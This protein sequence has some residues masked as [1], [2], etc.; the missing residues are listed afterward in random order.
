MYAKTT[1]RPVAAR[2]ISFGVIAGLLSMPGQ[3]TSGEQA[4]AGAL[5]EI[6][7]TAR[8]R[9]ESLM[10]TPVAITALTADEL[11]QRQIDST[12]QI[13]QATPNLIFRNTASTSNTAAVVYIRGIGQADFVPTIQPGVGTYVDGGYVSSIAGALTDIVDVESINVLRG[14]QG[15]LFGRN[16]IGGAILIN[17]RKPSHVFSANTE[18]ILGNLE[19]RQFKGSVNVPFGDTFFGIFSVLWRHKDGH[20]DTPNIPGDDGMGSDDT[21]AARMALRWLATDALTI[22]LT[23]DVSRQENDGV[24]VV[25]NYIDGTVPGT[26]AFAWNTLAA[27]A[28]GQPRYTASSGYVRAPGE[29][30]N[31]AS[32]SERNRSDTVNGT[33]TAEWDL[34]AVSLKSLTTY[35][36]QESNSG[37]DQDASPLA[38]SYLANTFD[39][40][41]FSQELQLSGGSG[42]ERLKWLVGLYYFTED[43]INIGPVESVRNTFVSGAIVDNRSAAAFGQLTYD[44][45]DRLSVT[46]GGRYTDEEMHSIVDDRHQYVTG[47]FNPALPGFIAVPPPP[48]AGAIRIQ[49]N[50]KF[51]TEASEFDPYVNVS[52]QWT[53]TLMTYASYSTGFKSG[54]FTQ[55]IAPGRTVTAFDPEYVEVYEIGWKWSTERLRATGAVFVTDY[56]DLQVNVSRQLG[57]NLQNASDAQLKGFELELTAALTPRLQVS[58]GTGYLDSKYER[59]MPTVEFSIDNRLPSTPEWQANASATYRLPVG[60][61]SGEIVTRVDWSFVDDHF[62]EAQNIPTLFQPSWSVFNAAVTYVHDSGNWEI[63]LQGR[64]IADKT[65]HQHSSGN[66]SAGGWTYDYLS[67]PAEYAL[68]LSCRF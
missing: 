11:A 57:G 29:H 32:R 49:P 24:P 1:L 68:R 27:P 14:P 53:D 8:K 28:L 52:Y 64:N 7:V 44:L 43:M 39:G 55:R 2:S 3:A 21:R 6:I 58:A 62:V 61:L 23:A 40:D 30:V 18:L 25:L 56:T 17:S 50:N 22:D 31:F 16:T 54:G 10:K 47:I 41:Q 15:T 38:I 33:L 19:R 59:V 20:V 37:F 48:A 45:T 46:L 65:Y 12:V 26:E 67:P 9:E 42:Q 4:T 36:N 60:A 13:A 63:G 35:R 66:L 34:G 51:T 5:E